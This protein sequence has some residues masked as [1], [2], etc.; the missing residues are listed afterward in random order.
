MKLETARIGRRLHN[1]IVIPLVAAIAVVG[2]GATIVGSV[3]V[4][5]LVE[6]WIDSRARTT[7]ESAANH[8]QDHGDLLVAHARLIA[9]DPRMEEALAADDV[10][11]ATRFLL[12]AR[13]A[14]GADNVLLLDEEGRVVAST[15][16]LGVE[17]GQL[18]FPED[19]ATWGPLGMTYPTVSQVGDHFAITALHGVRHPLGERPYRV[20]VSEAIDDEFM[21]QISASTEDF[22][23]FTSEAGACVATS[24][25]QRDS[26]EKAGEGAVATYF[27]DPAVGEALDA[28]EDRIVALDVHGEPFRATAMPIRFESDPSQGSGF[29]LAVVDA[30]V[31]DSARTTTIGL[32]IGFSSFSI[33][34]LWGL[35]YVIARRVS[36]SVAEVTMS[37]RSVS[38]GDFTHRVEGGGSEELTELSATFNEMTESLRERNESLTKKVLEMATLYEMSRVLSATLNL[39]TL[40]DS[41]LDSAMRIFD[42]ESGY[43]VLK[44]RETGELSMR[45]SRGVIAPTGQGE[46]KSSIAE[47]VV[48]ETRPLIF[49][50]T[51]DDGGSRI[52]AVTGASTALCVPLVSAEGSIGAICVGSKTDDTEFTNDDV[53]LLSTIANHATMAIGNTE[54]FSSLQEAYVATVRSLAEAVDAKDP[55][56][57]GHSD[58]VAEYALAIAE[59]MGLSPDQLRTIEMAAYLHDIGKIGVQE[60]ILMKP[61]RLT[62]TEMSEMRHHPLIGASILQ[63]AV[64]PWPVA[65]IIRHHH[66]RWDGKGYPSGLKG[67]E[68][69]LLARV[70]SVADSYEAMTADRPYR[71]GKDWRHGMEELRRCAGEQFDSAIV[72]AF[73][74]VLERRRPHLHTRDSGV[75][76]DVHPDEARAVFSAVCDGMFARFRRLGGPRLATNIE[77]RLN[78]LFAKEELSCTVAGGKLVWRLNGDLPFEEE[79]RVMRHV[80]TLI[81]GAM[82]TSAGSTLVDHFYGEAVANLSGRLR[83]VAEA[84]DLRPVR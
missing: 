43:V 78:A 45:A 63:P 6:R 70:L 59:E 2:I 19:S 14:I 75:P 31:A 74:A 68:T 57:R 11:E 51:R 60:S 76:V 34:G 9:E 21:R 32:I 79:T 36:G 33:L 46:A 53:R 73:E 71:R 15:G 81:S 48:R 1:Q 64:F 56:T 82:E 8:F 4:T 67:E 20:A 77:E 22:F 84:L 83:Q 49:S 69:P 35:G 80:V 10:V 13:P 40:L 37:A 30:S 28:P 66:E 29:L 62:D 27:D 17:H 23:C 5:D 7:V 54:L 52:D 24:Q 50:P 39:E 12:E 58:R 16:T 38:S 44:D 3:L 55:Y 61:G 65:P 72:D 41:V 42:L 25:E 47:W 18:P 26:G